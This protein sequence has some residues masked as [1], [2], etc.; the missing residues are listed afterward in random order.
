MYDCIGNVRARLTPSSLTIVTHSL[1]GT[2]LLGYLDD[3]GRNVDDD[4]SRSYLPSNVKG[5]DGFAVPV[6]RPPRSVP[7]MLPK[8]EEEEEDIDP[9]G[10]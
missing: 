10:K 4:E 6:P 3:S 7:S 8:D 5:N 9:L 2:L 1:I